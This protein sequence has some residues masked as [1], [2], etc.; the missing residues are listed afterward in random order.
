MNWLSPRVFFEQ[1]HL[2]ILLVENFNQAQAWTPKRELFSYF[3]TRKHD[4]L[5]IFPK[6]LL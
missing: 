4:F 5:S 1:N 2:L 6:V 3:K